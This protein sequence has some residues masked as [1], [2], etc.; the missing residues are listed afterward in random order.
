VFF[1]VLKFFLLTKII[2]LKKTKT[3]K[4]TIFQNTKKTSK[5]NCFKHFLKELFFFLFK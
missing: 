5:I 4:L 2:D 3:Y 1:S